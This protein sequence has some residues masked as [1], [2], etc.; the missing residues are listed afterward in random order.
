MSRVDDST[1]RQVHGWNRWRRDPS[2]DT[3][4]VGDGSAIGEP[5]VG[6][7]FSEIDSVPWQS[8]PSQALGEVVVV[9]DVRQ[10]VA[11]D[12]LHDGAGAALVGDTEEKQHDEGH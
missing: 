6:Q 5:P 11:E 9:A 2:R 12:E 1:R 10:G 7:A 3:D 8:G 4:N